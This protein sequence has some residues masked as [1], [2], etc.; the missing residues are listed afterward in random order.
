MLPLPVWRAAIERD[1]LAPGF[2][3]AAM[4]STGCGRFERNGAAELG[5]HA[6]RVAGR[7]S[8]TDVVRQIADAVLYEGHVLWPYRRSSIK[9]R[10]R[11]TFGGIY[12]DA[13]A[14]SAGDRSAAQTEA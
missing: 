11:W 5:S 6:S 9:N 12:P 7:P 10:Q 4:P 3:S 1:F 13:Y 8:V 2:A 14:R